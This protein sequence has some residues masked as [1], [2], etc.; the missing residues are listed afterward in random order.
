LDPAV[1]NLRE[2]IALLFVLFLVLDMAGM[3]YG[4]SLAQSSPLDPDATLSQIP[5]TLTDLRG[6]SYNVYVLP[7][8]LFGYYGLFTAAGLSLLAMLTVIV[9][10][11]IQQLRAARPRA[12]AKRTR[13]PDQK[14]SSETRRLPRN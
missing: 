4:M 13:R 14:D 10:H 7:T 2:W 9:G 5:V 6:D 1:K 8:Q 3:Q 12:V 11:G